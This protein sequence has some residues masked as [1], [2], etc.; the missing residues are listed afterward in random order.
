MNKTGPHGNEDKFKAEI[1]LLFIRGVPSSAEIKPPFTRSKLV[2]YFKNEKNIDYHLYGSKTG[3]ITNGILTSKDGYLSLN[4]KDGA[5]VARMIKHLWNVPEIV[6]NVRY[7]FEK[8]F[9]EAFLSNY[10]DRFVIRLDLYQYLDKKNDR[11]K[12]LLS[13]EIDRQLRRE[14]NHFEE[15]NI[16]IGELEKLFMQYESVTLDHTGEE[17]KNEKQ[18]ELISTLIDFAWTRRYLDITFMLGYV[19]NVIEVSRTV[20]GIERNWGKISKIELF[21]RNMSGEFSLYHKSEKE[22][23]AFLR[24]ASPKAIEIFMNGVIRKAVTGSS[25]RYSA[26]NDNL[27]SLYTGRIALASF[28]V[29]SH[30]M[31]NITRYLAPLEIP[32]AQELDRTISTASGHSPTQL[33]ISEIIEVLNEHRSTQEKIMLM[34]GEAISNILGLETDIL[35]YT[36]EKIEPGFGAFLDKFNEIQ[37]KKEDDVDFLDL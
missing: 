1:L 18:E 7:F 34:E 24:K 21:E 31:D 3:L 15:L 10:G 37:N 11:T 36:W 30:V 32:T 16:K 17:R 29:K 6:P 9:I 26:E 28:I 14:P 23:M 13:R 33:E 20:E 12:S 25:D 22:I 35:G 5:A 8:A 27:L 4:L 2:Q 19:L